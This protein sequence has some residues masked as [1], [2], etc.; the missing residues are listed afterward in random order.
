MVSVDVQHHERKAS[1]PTVIHTFTGDVDAFCDSRCVGFLLDDFCGD[2]APWKK[3]KHAHR[4]T[5]LYWRCWRLLWQS[6]CRFSA[7]WFLWRY[8][9]MKERETCPP[10]YRCIPLL[11]MLTPSV[12]V[13]LFKGKVT[14]TLLFPLHESLGADDQWRDCRQQL[15]QTTAAEEFTEARV[16]DIEVHLQS[17]GAQVEHQL[18]ISVLDVREHC[19]LS[20]VV[21]VGAGTEE[22]VGVK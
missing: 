20:S 10:S 5:Y 19:D 16:Q 4:H 15:Q 12:T 18:S 22:V 14:P 2:T 3:G 9:T 11:E 8:S 21:S 13:G 7:W 1:M 6:V 17:Y